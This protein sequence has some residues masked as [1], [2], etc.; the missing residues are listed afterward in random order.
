M[1]NK[2][3]VPYVVLS[4]LLIISFLW[5]YGQYNK[6]R[7]YNI[8][9][10]NQYQRMFADMVVNLEDI[11]SNLAKTI[12]S[13]TSN[14]KVML[15]SDIS[16]LS[17]DAQ[18]KLCQLPVA[19]SQL[20]KTQKFLSQIGDLSKAL[21][22]KNLNGRILSTEEL[23]VLEELHNYSNEITKELIVAQRYM[24]DNGVSLY[25]MNREI[26]KELGATKVNTDN[27]AY[28]DERIQQYPTLIYDGPFSEHIGDRN[29]QVTGKEISKDMAIEKAKSFFNYRK[30]KVERVEDIKYMNE[31]SYL[32][33]LNNNG[34]RISSAITKK[35][36]HVIWML[37]NEEGLKKKFSREEAIKKAKDFLDTKGIKN[38]ATTYYMEYDNQVVVN[39]A[40]EQDKVIIYPD[41]IKVKISLEN[42]NVL[43]YE[44]QGYL[45]NHKNRDLNKEGLIGEKQA[46]SRLSSRGV[47]ESS[48]LTVIPTDAYGEKLCY[49]LK[50]TYKKD[51]FLI[52]INA[53]TGMEEKILQVIVKDDGVLVL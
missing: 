18:E 33:V 44:S 50:V 30:A 43:G 14:E 15:L 20:L 3:V 41:L 6:N 45:F 8:Y 7:Q 49:E 38:M 39:F 36:G 53:L 17:Y 12:V 29:F 11:Q 26:N 24:E 37:S 1:K 21:A 52:Y 23:N 40:Y 25:G 32:V 19:G 35:G 16:N 4:G 31:K 42:G 47:V 34:N 22:Q 48:R 10:E 5:G 51:T 28:M 13:S 9:L 46:I 27:F 2:N